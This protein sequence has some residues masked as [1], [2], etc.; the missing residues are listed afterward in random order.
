M[1]LSVY[2][3]HT[4]AMREVSTYEKGQSFCDRSRLTDSTWRGR[5]R[6]KVSIPRTQH[7]A[8]HLG[9]DAHRDLHGC[10][11]RHPRDARSSR[12]LFHEAWWLDERLVAFPTT[13]HVGLLKIAVSC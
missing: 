12:D 5:F 4:P 13:S 10:A 2:K 9:I 11:R 3:R 1:G 8:F 7:L 6:L